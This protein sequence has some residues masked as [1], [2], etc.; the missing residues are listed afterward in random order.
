MWTIVILL[1]MV[2]SLFVFSSIPKMGQGA[3]AIHGSFDIF[4]RH[5][6]L[7]FI[8]V[9]IMAALSLGLR[10]NWVRNL[11]ALPY[12]VF[13]GLTLAAYF[14]GTEINGATR[15]IF[16]IQPSEFLKV[17]AVVYLAKVIDDRQDIIQNEMFIPSVFPWRWKRKEQ[18]ERIKT[19][20][21][22]ILWPI[23]LACVVIAPAHSSSALQIY[24][25]SAVM[26]LIAGAKKSEVAKLFA[27]LAILAMLYSLVGAARSNVVSGRIST[28]AQ[29]LYKPYEPKSVVDFTDTER[30]MVAIHHGGALGVGAGKSLVRARMTHPESDYIYA[31][32]VE[33]YGFIMAVSLMILYLWFLLRAINVAKRSDWLF[34][35]LLAIGLGFSIVFQAFI[36]IAVSLNCFPETGQTLPLV[37]KG[38]SSLFATAIAVGL[39][40]L[41]S[42]KVEMDSN[43]PYIRIKDRGEENGTNNEIR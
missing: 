20:S 38:G 43:L 1:L 2:S 32:A 30:A 5:L 40:I 14:F 9:G 34:A 12:C 10:V 36:H 22:P 37:S 31:L 18:W 35:K 39:I 23:A 29:S 13:I 19:K 15:W 4:I 24:I 41:V 16:G 8:G 26:F 3:S 11:A 28:W 7:V 42:R 25:V 17:A 33:E 6:G 27:A 21:I